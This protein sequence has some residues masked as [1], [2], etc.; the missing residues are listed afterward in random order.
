MIKNDR[1]SV[2]GSV[3]NAPLAFVLDVVVH[4]MPEGDD[5]LTK[6]AESIQLCQLPV[7]PEQGLSVPGYLHPLNGYTMHGTIFDVGVLALDS[8]V[9]TVFHLTEDSL[10]TAYVETPADIPVALTISET[11][12]LRKSVA[13]STD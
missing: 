5:F 12:G 9:N 6:T 10:V 7:M 1:S 2:H 3:R 13:L 8:G 11:G 4:T